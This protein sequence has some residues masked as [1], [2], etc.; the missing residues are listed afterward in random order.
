M[1]S[2]K[3][4]KAAWTTRT[5]SSS[6]ER[7]ALILDDLKEALTLL[8]TLQDSLAQLLPG[9]DDGENDDSSFEDEDTAFASHAESEFDLNSEADNS[10][11]DL[12]EASEEDQS[13]R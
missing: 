5:F 9:Q 7:F 8:E 1:A 12:Q 6:E 13:A 3:S 2:I 10:E 11:S 4:G